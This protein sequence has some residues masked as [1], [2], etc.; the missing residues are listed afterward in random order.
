MLC[1]SRSPS[2]P[3][4]G[5]CS[6]FPDPLVVATERHEA[7][8]PIAM[9]CCSVVHCHVED[10]GLDPALSQFMDDGCA[11]HLGESLPAAVGSSENIPHRGHCER[12]RE[13]VRPSD[14]N[15]GSPI[16]NPKERAG[17]KLPWMKGVRPV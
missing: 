7:Q 9:Q 8:I 2:E 3:E 6:Q 11:R 5:D 13:D 1:S 14:A 12:T 16:P 17:Q 4:F 10:N 15:Q